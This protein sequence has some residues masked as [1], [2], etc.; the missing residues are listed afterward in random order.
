MDF[1]GIREDGKRG[2]MQ[3]K[4]VTVDKVKGDTSKGER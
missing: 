1:I 2:K 3:R 4:R